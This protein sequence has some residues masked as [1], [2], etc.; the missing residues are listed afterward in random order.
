MT[1][2]KVA[3][4]NYLS[5]IISIILFIIIAAIL[6]VGFF[7]VKQT[8]KQLR[9]NNGRLDQIEKNIAS[10]TSQIEEQGKANQ[11]T[12]MDL[13][14]WIKSGT[15]QETQQLLS[16]LTFLLQLANL[17]LTINHDPVNCQLLLSQAY[18]RIETNQEPLLSPL[19]SALSQDIARLKSAPNVNVASLIGRLDGLNQQIQSISINKKKYNDL[20]QS[21]SVSQNN[22]HNPS[23]QNLLPWYKQWRNI[24]NAFK[25]VVIIRRTESLV[26]PLLSPEQQLFLKEN[27]QTK[28]L[29]AQWAVLHQEPELYQQ[30]LNM[31][32]QW[33]QNYFINFAS[34]KTISNEINQLLAINVKPDLPDIKASLNALNQTIEENASF[35]KSTPNA[36]NQKNPLIPEINIEKGAS[37]SAP[38]TLPHPQP[39]TNTVPIV[40]E[41][42][43]T[44]AVS[45][46]LSRWGSRFREDPI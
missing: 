23:N 24:L 26:T 39:K 32:K 17:H 10:I 19:K 9:A 13:Y 30:S 4:K 12:Q 31:V 14:R 18:A 11:K 16:Q 6:V 46:D 44:P 38:K 37:K 35:S 42:S 34:S 5:A 25:E 7:F 22:T 20:T 8:Q 3:M 43:S 2:I 15:H 27:I 21:G 29:Q 40:F 41:Y 33:F 28:L 36:N 45:A 1:D